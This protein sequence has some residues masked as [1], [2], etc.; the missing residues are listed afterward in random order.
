MN[1]EININL[2]DYIVIFV[3]N[4]RFLIG[5]TFLSMIV[6]YLLILFFVEEKFDSQATIIPAQDNSISGIASMLG[7][8]GG[9]P[10]GIGTSSNP[11]IGL[12]NTILKSRT[13][14]EKV[15]SKFNLWEVYKLNPNEPKDVKRARERI[16]D[17]MSGEETDDGA[18]TIIIRTPDAKLS[19]NIAN[20]LLE[21]LNDKIIEL[22]VD[23]SKKNRIFL[24][25]RLNEMRLKLADS[26]DALKNF[27]AKT[28]FLIPEEQIK[29]ILSTYSLLEKDLVSK[30]LQ[31]EVMEKLLEKNS[32]KLESIKLEVD[33][34]EK[35][36]REIKTNGKENSIF[37]PYPN[38]PKYALE[39][40]RLYREIEINNSILKFVLPLYEQARIEEQKDIPIL[41]VIDYAKPAEI[42]SFPKR[43]IF[44]LVFGFGMFIL[45]F[46][47][48][49]FSENRNIKNLEKY[50][51]VI[52]N[53]FIWKNKSNIS[54]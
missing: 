54:I 29:S 22:K 35:Q 5:Y 31:K 33:V 34:F 27:Q 6:F 42:K 32:P 1:N 47:I 12:Y 7:D 37:I 21:Y 15:I 2:I 24:E 17:D 16:E 3:K 30:Q 51:Y 40:Y 45:L 25:S 41:Q 11:E 48:K 26:E 10:F 18:Y 23:K 9:L 28:G 53:L 14:I 46:G 44:T 38:I 39:Y 13:T 4:K 19:A 52:N 49:V 36:L 20:Y 43:S 50:E 8:L